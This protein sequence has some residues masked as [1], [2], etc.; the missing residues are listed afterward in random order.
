M[1]FLPYRRL[2]SS[3]TAAA[4][5]AALVLLAAPRTHAQ[6]TVS[7]T[8]GSG[9]PLTIALAT[10][11]SYTIT[12]A[13][14]NVTAPVF[15]LKGVG[16]VFGQEDFGNP[17]SVTGSITFRINNGAVQNIRIA[18]SNTQG[19]DL[20]RNDIFLYSNLN[21][22]VSVGDIVTLTSGTLTTAGNVGAS[23]PAGGT[24]DTFITVGSGTRISTNGIAIT[25]APEPCSISLLLV[26]CAGMVGVVGTILQNKKRAL[27]HWTTV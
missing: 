14:S 7:F 4:V 2:I 26:M 22:A 25:A 19:P 16:N 10:P 17:S 9:T 21:S 27:H 8:G 1:R 3:L 12:T 24:F 13:A 15:L 5:P 20:A 18:G 11:V 6:A 23:A